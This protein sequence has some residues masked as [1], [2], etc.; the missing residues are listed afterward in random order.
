MKSIFV[1][2][3]HTVNVGDDLFFHI[4]FNRYP[5]TRMIIYAP[6]VYK[7][8][9]KTFNNVIV[10]SKEDKPI[11]KLIKFSR[12]LHI[13][14]LFLIYTYIFIRYH[15]NCF[16]VIGGSLFMEG[17][18]NM[19]Q[20]LNKLH[21]MKF[22]FPRIKVAIMGSNF[23]PCYS[24]GFYETV[25]KALSYTDDVCFRDK[26]S[27]E[28]FSDLPNVRWGNDIVLHMDTDENK[29]KKKMI[30]IN[31]RSVEKWPTLKPY[32]EKYLDL[33][34]SQITEYQQN[35]WGGY[36]F[37]PFVKNMVMMILQMNYMNYLKIKA[38]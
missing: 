14:E 29:Q 12:L 5:N 25:R 11:T 33:I 26:V 4:L 32:K 8:I 28:M 15:V 2:G 36:I 38:A 30:C 22:L 17:N 3:I 7:S 24:T 10:L 27:Y 13:P 6:F 16:L 18:T 23:G 9:F 20:L 35:N 21:K 1:S 19:P 31:I 37:S 34:H